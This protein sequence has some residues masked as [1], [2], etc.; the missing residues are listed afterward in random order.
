MPLGSKRTCR[1]IPAQPDRHPLGVE[2][3]EGHEGPARSAE[4]VTAVDGQVDAPA[5]ARRDQLV[6]GAVYGGVFTADGRPRD[7]AERLRRAQG[8]MSGEGL[9]ECCTV[10]GLYSLCLDVLAI[11]G[12]CLP[13][14]SQKWVLSSAC[15]C[16]EA[17]RM[18]FFGIFQF[19]IKF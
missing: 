5:E 4:P 9:C 6:D 3:D 2:E 10:P 11:G 17:F 12:G 7:K 1:Y 18:L 16:H 8:G 15:G 14:K 13:S 19:P